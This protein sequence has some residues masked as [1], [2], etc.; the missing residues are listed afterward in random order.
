M[1]HD[2]WMGYHDHHYGHQH[3]VTF[4][5]HI[6]AYDM[7]HNHITNLLLFTH[8]A[9]LHTQRLSFWL[10]VYLLQILHHVHHDPQ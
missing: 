10:Q 2:D 7:D 9:L 8:D 3:G 1:F 6:H 5:G 4:P